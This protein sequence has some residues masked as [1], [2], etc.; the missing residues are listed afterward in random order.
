MYH[1]TEAD[2]EG[3]WKVNVDGR[4]P[5]QLVRG[6]VRSPLVFPNGRFVVFLSSSPRR[7]VTLDRSD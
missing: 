1:A 4:Q 2:R 3:L 6:H 5:E 7:A